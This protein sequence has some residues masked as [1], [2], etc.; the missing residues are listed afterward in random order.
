MSPS[1][2]RSA[3]T[4]V[5]LEV[6][7]KRVFACAVEWPGWSRGGRSEA[8]A[9][10]ALL[11]AAPRYARV[12]ARSRLGFDPPTTVDQLRVVERLRGNATTEFGAPGVPPRA[13]AAPLD[14]SGLRRSRAVLEAAWR[15]FDA[16]ARGA[17]GRTLAKG[18]RG[19]GRDLDAIVRHVR[20]AEDA[21]RSGLGWKD[22]GARKSSDVAAHRRSLLTGLEASARGE[23]PRKG[24]RGG[25]R[26]T[27]RYF[28]RRAAWHVL[29]HLWEIE[30]RLAGGA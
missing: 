17:G 5:Y 2:R 24:P 3:M 14:A 12:L 29:D 4:D 11:A 27:A 25:V 9:L 8:E 28:T 18:P 10:E 6:G 26:W 20:E 16:T 22:D 19:G 7:T 21:Y 1:A 23:I 13:D 30:D 15:A